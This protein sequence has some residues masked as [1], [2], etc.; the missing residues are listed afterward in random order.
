MKRT[1]LLLLACLPLLCVPVFSQGPG[2]P[3][4]TNAGAPPMPQRGGMEY[5]GREGER[6]DR[7]REHGPEHG[8]LMGIPPG[9]WWK[10]PDLV[11]KI[12]LT[13]DQQAK[14]DEIFR[15]NRL[16][17]VDTKASLEKEQI[18]LEPLLNANPVDT[19]KALAEI[20]KIA[21]LRAGLEK[22]NAKMLLGLRSVLTA[23]QWTKLHAHPERG[24]GPAGAPGGQ[25]GPGQRGPRGGGPGV[26]PQGGSTPELF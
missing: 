9:T 14:M 13:A 11:A 23:D 6:M 15:Q 5:H 4:Q 26:P 7:G 2:A 19:N 3:P 20:S 8:G 18:N 17:L 22:A 16:Q 24:T 12:S 1:S 10:N 21:D 25:G